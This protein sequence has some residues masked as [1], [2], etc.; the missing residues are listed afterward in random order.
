MGDAQFL[1]RKG[2]RE[3]PLEYD[4][5][6]GQRAPYKGSPL[7]LGVGYAYAVSNASTCRL[8]NAASKLRWPDAVR[9]PRD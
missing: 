9:S 3:V 5:R 4:F 1:V 6:N 7:D 8:S 2:Y